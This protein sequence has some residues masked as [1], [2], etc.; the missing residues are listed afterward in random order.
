MRWRFVDRVTAFGPWQSIAGRKAVSLEEY[1]LLEPL[2]RQG[3]LP[4]S[5]V[6]ECCVE[7]AR[8]LVAASSDFRQACVLEGID[9]FE[10]R[11]EAVMGEILEVEARLTGSPEAGPLRA[12]C[13]V[14]VGAREVAGGSIAL[15]LVPLA[16]GFDPDFTASMWRELHGST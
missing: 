7:L 12:E 11:S 8:W 3:V 2:G 16:E 5:L 1:K 15:G 14:K 13:R 6:L 4:E 9:G 10:F